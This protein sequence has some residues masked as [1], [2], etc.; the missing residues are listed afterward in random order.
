MLGFNSDSNSVCQKTCTHYVWN[1]RYLLSN[2]STASPLHHC[3]TPM[4]KRH[5]NTDT[6][7]CAS[8]SAPNRSMADS[9]APFMCSCA[10]VLVRGNTEWNESAEEGRGLQGAIK[11]KRLGEDELLR[12]YENRHL[13]YNSNPVQSASK[14]KLGGSRGSMYGMG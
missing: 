9:D 7:T 3:P 2:A 13:L 8:K 11:P 5:T 6:C 12:I 4:L 14:E 1:S 10:D